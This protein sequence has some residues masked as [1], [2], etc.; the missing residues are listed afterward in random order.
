MKL[1]AWLL[2]LSLLGGNGAAIAQ[3]ATLDFN[4]SSGP[5]EQQLTVNP[6]SVTVQVPRSTKPDGDAP[7]PVVTVQVSGKTVFRALRP[8]LP[9]L[10][11][12][13]QIAEMDASNPYPEVIVSHYTGGAHCCNQV[14]VISSDPTGKQWRSLDLGAFDGGPHPLEDVD[15]DGQWEF[16][17]RDNRFLY[18]FSSYAGSFAPVQVWQLKNGKFVDVSRQP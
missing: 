2:A 6:V 4:A 16:V 13:L 3:A 7:P 8:D 9:G 12:L 1:S 17:D 11:T 18:Q 5:G 15:G 14:E 10:Q